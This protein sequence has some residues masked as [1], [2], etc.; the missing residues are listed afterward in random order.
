M[1]SASGARRR[2][3]ERGEARAVTGDEKAAEQ[4]LCE[5]PIEV[6]GIGQSF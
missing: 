3:V 1:A 5:I 6:A 2:R 4:G